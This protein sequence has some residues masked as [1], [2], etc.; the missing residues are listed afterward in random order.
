MKKLKTVPK[1][2]GNKRKCAKKEE[3]VEEDEEEVGPDP[4]SN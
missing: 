2:I 1:Q 3:S 4:V